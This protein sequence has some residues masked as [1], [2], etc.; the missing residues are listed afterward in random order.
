MKKVL[1]NLLFNQNFNLEDQEIPN[2]NVGNLI[3][4]KYFYN[5]EYIFT[6]EGIVIAKKSKGY[7][8]TITLQHIAEK[9][10]VIQIF[11]IF[12]PNIFTILKKDEIKYRRAKLYF[13]ISK[14]K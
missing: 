2:L 7:N 9:I 6:C 1:K 4:L 12:S 13:L 10:K 14:N 3:Q 8:K 11:P 5:S